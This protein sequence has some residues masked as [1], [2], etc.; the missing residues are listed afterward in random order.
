[1]SEAS[2]RGRAML[3]GCRLILGTR[4]FASWGAPLDDLIWPAKT[5][6]LPPPSDSHKY[7]Q[8][9]KQSCHFVRRVSGGNTGSLFDLT[10]DIF[11]RPTTRPIETRASPPTSSELSTNT[12]I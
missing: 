3:G 11:R 4:K 6:L 12:F 7:R 9:G 10:E 2:E 5:T 8:N 1:M